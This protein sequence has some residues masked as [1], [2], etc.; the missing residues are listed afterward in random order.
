MH[1]MMTGEMM[2]GMGL[3]WLLVFLVLVLEIAA[4][5]SIFGISSRSRG[6]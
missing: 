5:A 4:L 3:T 6:R 1:D 2:W